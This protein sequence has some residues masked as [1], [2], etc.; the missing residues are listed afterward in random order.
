MELAAS[1]SGMSSL[2]LG[3]H[4]VTAAAQNI[5]VWDGERY[6][7]TNLMPTD[8]IS[9][10]WMTQPIDVPVGATAVSLL[11]RCYGVTSGASEGTVIVK[12]LGVRSI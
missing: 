12:S 3:I 6:D 11:V 9:G 2:Q 7:T 1:S 10:V 5:Y 4:V 8:K